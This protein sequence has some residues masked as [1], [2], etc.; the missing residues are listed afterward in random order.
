MAV[1]APPYPVNLLL[2]GRR[3]L[4]VGGGSVAAAK[5]AGLL[6]AEALVHVVA[7]RVSPE[8]RAMDVTWQ[9]RPYARGEVTGYRYVVACTDEP[10][11]NQAVFDDAEAAGIFVNAA[12]DPARCSA[13]LPARLDRGPLLVTVST[14]GHSPA[15]AGWLRDRLADVVGPEHETLV[16]LLAEARAALTAAGASRPAADWRRALDSGMLDLI[17]EGRIDDAK[18]LLAATLAAEPF[19]PEHS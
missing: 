11:T 19:P 16:T 8:I 18:A 5:I 9:E 13:T 1:P 12:D 7:T 3:V 14:S 15:L 2:A 10:E 4:V 17:R 6:A